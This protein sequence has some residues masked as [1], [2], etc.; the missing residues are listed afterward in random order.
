M[1]GVYLCLESST[2]VKDTHNLYDYDS[3]DKIPQKMT[4]KVPGS[5]CRKADVLNFH[6]ENFSSDC[7]MIK[8]Y[9]LGDQ[10]ILYPLKHE[11]LGLIIKNLKNHSTRGYKLSIGETF[12]LGRVAMKVKD[13]VIGNYTPEAHESIEDSFKVE[14]ACRVCFTS[15]DTKN[16]PLVSLCSCTGSLKWMHLKCLQNWT[17]A[18]SYR[19]INTYVATYAWT[20]LECD[21]CKDKLPTTFEHQGQTYSLIDL[22]KHGLNYIILEDQRKDNYYYIIHILFPQDIPISIGRGNDNDMKINDIS[23]S[24]S[25]AMITFNHNFYLKDL[26][27]RF[28]TIVML[29]KPQAIDKSESLMVQLNRTTIKFSLK[30]EIHLIDCVKSCCTKHNSIHSSPIR[31]TLSQLIMD[32]SN[33]H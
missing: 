25:H 22:P 3:S 17:M 16:N 27:S 20:S 1:K 8:I 33:D 5:I 24:R 11:P 26:N 2:W 18:R 21:I 4:L 29:T 28:G 15:N 31:N 23:I 9:E 6:P 12:K 7:S 19:K 10:F 13:I 32:D 30:T 14:N